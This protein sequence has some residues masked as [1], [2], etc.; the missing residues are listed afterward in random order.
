MNLQWDYDKIANGRELSFEPNWYLYDWN[1]VYLEMFH[2][3]PCQTTDY[4]C[5]ILFQLQQKGQ[6]FDI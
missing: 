6:I 2:S 1:F 4:L 5:L 3:M